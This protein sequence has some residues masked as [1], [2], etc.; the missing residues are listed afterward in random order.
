MVKGILIQGSPQCDGEGNVYYKAWGA[1]L[2]TNGPLV[3]ISADGRHV[4]D[5]TL[6]TVPDF[7]RDKS[8]G[9]NSISAWTLGLRAE[10][11]LLAYKEDG[12][13]LLHFDEEGKFQALTKVEARFKVSQLAVFPTGEFLASGEKLPER[14]DRR[15]EPFT[16]IFDRNGN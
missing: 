11:H 1:A 12:L 7:R 14:Q 8:I 10:V 6:D 2:P 4:V 5:I 13:Y 16:A 15:G 9:N 3:R